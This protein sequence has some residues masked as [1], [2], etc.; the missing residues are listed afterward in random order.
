MPQYNTKDE[1]A[2]AHNIYRN[3]YQVIKNQS[4]N[5]NATVNFSGHNKKVFSHKSHHFAL[6]R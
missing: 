4:E 3:M 1:V 6:E 5:I 2:K